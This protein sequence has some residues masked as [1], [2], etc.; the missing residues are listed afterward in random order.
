MGGGLVRSFF[1]VD[2]AV[3]SSA[4]ISDVFNTADYAWGSVQAPAALT[5]TAL[6]FEVSLDGTNFSPLTDAAGLDV[7]AITL[8]VDECF[9]LPPELFNYRFARLKL[10]GNEAAARTFKLLMKG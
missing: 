1:E 4:S 7:A 2:L 9:T 3:A 10:D 6:T 8:T 5:N